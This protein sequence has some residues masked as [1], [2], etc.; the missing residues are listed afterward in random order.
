MAFRN[1]GAAIG[2]SLTTLYTVPANYEAVIHSLYISNT[3][4]VN[5]ITVEI[6]A[7]LTKAGLGSQYLA[8]N[9]TIPAGT[10]LVFDKP[11]NLRPT[12]ILQ[13][14][15]SAATCEAFASILLTAEDT[16]APN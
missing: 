12:D 9:V 8:Q 7:T 4:T 3:D 6:Q 5:T 1:A 10:S 13:V 15:A 11:I 14:K 2:T 16:V